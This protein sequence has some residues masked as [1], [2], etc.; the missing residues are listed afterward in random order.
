MTWRLVAVLSIVC[1][2]TAVA[3]QS[4]F[5]VAG[6][7]LA[8]RAVDRLRYRG[9]IQEQ[10]GYFAGGEGWIRVGPVSLG[11]RGLTGSLEGADSSA[12][13]DRRNVRLST[14]WVRVRPLRWLA[15]GPE[16]EARRYH[17]DLGA[18][19]WR[20]IGAGVRFSPE[21]SSAGFSGILEAAY[22]PVTRL[23]GSERLKLATRGEFGVRYV[24]RRAHIM[25]QVVYRL[26]R[27]DF[28]AT[29]EYPVR[30]EQTSG[31][32]AGVGVRIGR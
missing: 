18:V 9:E 15:L 21:F 26:E 30:L 10:S 13:V 17:S 12:A 14:V 3:Q 24:S 23:T 6:S 1:S 28:E 25:L 22:F 31:V 20:L 27:Y 8:L 16:A 32:L 29:S 5:E 7:G 4:L 11:G 19:T 2:S